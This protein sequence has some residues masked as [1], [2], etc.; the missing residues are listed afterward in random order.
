MKEILLNKDNNF[1]KKLKAL[2]FEYY[3]QGFLF[4]HYI[5]NNGLYLTKEKLKASILGDFKHFY[6]HRKA[7]QFNSLKNEE[8]KMNSSKLNFSD[9]I[10]EKGN[11][12][13]IIKIKSEKLL[14]TCP[15]CEKKIYVKDIDF[16]GI[17]FSK[18]NNFPFDYLHIHSSEKYPFHA[19]LIYFDAQ[20][21]VRWRKVAKFTN[22]KSKIN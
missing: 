8:K 14:T 5:L 6:R 2:F 22:L 17:D 4:G 20:L 11:N 15:L 1:F 19:L 10:I 3:K 12:S 18:I 21:N 9:I 13:S 16:E 7:D